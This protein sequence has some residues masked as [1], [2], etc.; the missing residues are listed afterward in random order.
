MTDVARVVKTF[1]EQIERLGIP[2]AVGGSFASGAWGD[3]RQTN[4]LDVAVWITPEQGDLLATA[5]QGEFLIYAAEIRQTLADPEPYRSFQALHADEIFKIDV[6]VPLDTPY[7]RSEFER[8]VRVELL[9]GLFVNCLTAENIVLRKLLWYEAG[10]RVSDRQWNDIL[11][12]LEF[13][14]PK[15]DYGY[16]GR[17]ASELGIEGL[18]ESALSERTGEPD[19][20]A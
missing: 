14:G 4:D 1:L 17:W 9:P 7:V 2:Y 18:L 15:L 16:L 8:A 12:V 10:H 6:F 5:L 13:Q 3:P 20:F 11:R 19:P